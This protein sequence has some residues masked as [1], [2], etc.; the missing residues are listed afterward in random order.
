MEM[1]GYVAHKEKMRKMYTL[2]DGKHKGKEN[3]LK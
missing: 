2:L 1:V 3:I